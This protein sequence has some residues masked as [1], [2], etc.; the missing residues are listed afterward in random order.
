M[1]A[2]TAQETIPA[3]AEV[4]ILNKN[5][6]KARKL[7]KGTGIKKVDG[8]QR[9]VLRRRGG[10]SFVIEKPDVYRTPN[11]GYIV[12]GEAKVQNQDFAQQ[13]AALNQGGASEAAAAAAGDD[14][15]PEAITKDL[16]AAVNKVSIEEEPEV[17]DA[18]VDTTGLDED[19]IT[20]IIEQ[21][22]VSKAKAVKALRENNGDLVN[23]LMALTN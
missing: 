11:G 22:N 18:D 10:V 14:K 3:G 7:L 13:L 17:D 6:K 5:E 12:F 21:A 20:M 2:E 9:V 4:S 1:S 16:E 15:S 8:I 23:T 19:K